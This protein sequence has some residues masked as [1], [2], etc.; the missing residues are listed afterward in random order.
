MFGD[1][2]KTGALVEDVYHDVHS[3][4]INDK[5]RFDLGFD[6]EELN[7]GKFE[8][9]HRSIEIKQDAVRKEA[10]KI[11]NYGDKQDCY[12]RI[13]DNEGILMGYDKENGIRAYHIS[14]EGRSLDFA[15]PFDAI[16]TGKALGTRVFADVNYR[17]QLDERRRGFDF[18]DGLFLLLNS[19]V[20]SYDFNNKTGGYMQ[21]FLIDATN[22][23]IPQ[24]TMEKADHGLFLSTEII[25]AF[26]WGYI[27]RSRAQSM[28]ERLILKEEG[29]EDMER[30]LFETCSDSHSL[31]KHLMGYKPA[32]V[33]RKPLN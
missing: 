8:V 26:R 27:D 12:H 32:D 25:R 11:M 3:R 33:P 18:S 13:F 6:R 31:R 14:H 16:G 2:D 20:D 5:L 4:M 15:Y 10:R 30:E 28:V 21:L 1:L 9:N 24:M 19:F 23:A 17:M 7:Q 29:W 22:S